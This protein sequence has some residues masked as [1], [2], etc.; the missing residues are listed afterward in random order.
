MYRNKQSWYICRFLLHFL[1]SILQTQLSLIFFTY[2][3]S[4]NNYHWHKK[5]HFQQLGL[6]MFLNLYLFS[7]Y[8]WN[9]VEYLSDSFSKC[10]RVSLLSKTYKA[11]KITILRSLYMRLLYTK[12]SILYVN[13]F[14][15]HH[16]WKRFMIWE[17]LLLNLILLN[18][19]IFFRHRMMFHFNVLN[20]FHV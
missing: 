17:E 19:N 2:S 12:I 1:S 8:F 4:T 9:S 5:W 3:A 15:M 16:P 14:A 10:S 6:D 13:A 20:S 18:M 7:F 11:G